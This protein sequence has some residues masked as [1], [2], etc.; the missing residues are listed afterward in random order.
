MIQKTSF[1]YP[2]YILMTQCKRAAIA[3]EWHLFCIELS[4]A[5]LCEYKTINKWSFHCFYWM[6]TSIKSRSYNDF[7]AR[8]RYLRHGYVT[9]LH[10]ILWD[11]I[12][13]PCPRYLLLAPKSSYIKMYHFTYWIRIYWVSPPKEIISSVVFKESI[14]QSSDTHIVFQE[15]QHFLGIG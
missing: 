14:V 5:I 1:G 7:G 4:I 8:S 12:T 13:Y 9:T 10:C 11:V 3:K 6:H 2:K 15:N